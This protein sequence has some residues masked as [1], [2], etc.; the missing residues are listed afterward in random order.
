MRVIV[1]TCALLLCATAQV[2]NT[3]D[4]EASSS[5]D[6]ASPCPSATPAN[7]ACCINSSSPV[8]G[9]IDF[10]DLATKVQATDAPVFGDV[11]FSAQL[12]GYMFHFKSDENRA[13]FEADPWKFAPAWGGF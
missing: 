13:A 3:D 4:D 12:N 7:A 11:S 8:M 10:V 9:G 2:I 6:P 5:I 1:V